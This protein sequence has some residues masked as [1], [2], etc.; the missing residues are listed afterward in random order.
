MNDEKTSGPVPGP[1]N[2]SFD[3]YI[4]GKSTFPEF[5]H[6]VYLDQASGIELAE[7]IEEYETTV[8]EIEALR[9]KQRVL[10]EAGGLSLADDKL[11]DIS[12]AVSAADLDIER[13]DRSISE[14]TEKIKETGVCLHFEAGT[15]QKFSKVLRKADKAYTKA[16]GAIDESDVEHITGRTRNILVHQLSSYCIGWETPSEKEENDRLEKEAKEKGEKFKRVLRDAPSQESFGAMLDSL[17]G[18]ETMR[19]LTALNKGL[20]ASAEWAS[21]I[22]AGFPGGGSDLGA[23]SLGGAGSENSSVMGGPAA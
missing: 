18:S 19:L 9:E 6:T 17:I 22:D 2:F 7:A 4:S 12:D 20:D 8:K 1:D 3:A 13:L 14:L 16:H 5:S 23:G 11:S 15:P 10:V 21:R